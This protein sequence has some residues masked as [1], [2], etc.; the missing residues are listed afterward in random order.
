[1]SVEYG[2][3]IIAESEPTKEGSTFSG[4]SG[5]PSTMPARDVEIT[6]SFDSN[7]YKLIY[8]LDGEIYKSSIVKYGSEITAEPAPVREDG[9]GR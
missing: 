4:W 9:D 2:S 7:A 8:K 6:G 3:S 5:V 1:M